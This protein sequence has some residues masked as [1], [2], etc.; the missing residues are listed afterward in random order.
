MPGSCVRSIPS[1]LVFATLI[2]V[3]VDVNDLIRRSVAATQADWEAA[4]RYRYRERDV[5]GGKIE[6]YEVTMIEGSPYYRLI[7]Q[8]NRP[9]SSEHELEE[10]A[11]FQAEVSRRRQ[12]SPA[13]RAKR[14]AAY[15]RERDED[16]LFL[17]EMADAF[18]YRLLGEQVIDGRSVFAL[19][20]TP[21]PDY[22]PINTKA[23]ILTRMHGK[24]WIDKAEYQWVKVEAEVTAPV[25]LYLVAHVG[26][27]TRFSLEQM[28]IETNLWLP[29][30]FAM[31]TRV[32]IL[33]VPQQREKEETYSDYRPIDPKAAE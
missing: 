1:L 2:H 6:T 17:K 16:H 21:R 33:G 11:R 7:A 29:K 25:S 22:R 24:L 19:E 15:Q 8:N 18:V 9:L 31:Q 13:Q 23:K 3:D 20:A 28:P 27:G 30:R 4:P 32:R 12:E 10:K 5:K 14:L 26:P